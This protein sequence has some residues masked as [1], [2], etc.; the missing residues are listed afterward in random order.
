M[1]IFNLAKKKKLKSQPQPK[2]VVSG[3]ISKISL[4]QRHRFECGRLGGI[5]II[6]GKSHFQIDRFDMIRHIYNSIGRMD[7]ILFYY[8]LKQ[9]VDTF[10]KGGKI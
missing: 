1:H 2:S 5:N 3:V 7:R 6:F 9:H 10:T 4:K 8:K